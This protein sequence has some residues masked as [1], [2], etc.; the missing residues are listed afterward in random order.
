MENVDRSIISMESIRETDYPYYIAAHK[1]VATR[2]EFLTLLDEN[3]QKELDL[4]DLLRQKITG[5]VDIEDLT[6]E[7]IRASG[8]RSE[9]MVVQDY[10]RLTAKVRIYALVHAGE[11]SLKG[12]LV[13]PV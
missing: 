8:V 2:A 12:N 7:F 13:V 4:Y 6:S 1:G 3:I 10:V 5:P 11:Y 9:K